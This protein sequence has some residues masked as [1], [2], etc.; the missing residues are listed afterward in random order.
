MR[1]ETGDDFIKFVFGR[2]KILNIDKKRRIIE[3]WESIIP[4][5]E[6]RG[7][8][9]NYH[10]KGRRFVFY[11]ML[12]TERRLHKITPEMTDEDSIEKVLDTLRDIVPVEVKI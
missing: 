11:V 12:L 5:N 9:K 3:Y 7:Y 2:R 6:V 4:F 8:W 1:I 10:P